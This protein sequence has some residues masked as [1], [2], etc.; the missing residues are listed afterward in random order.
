[1][2]KIYKVSGYWL[3]S[4]DT[5]S[6]CLITDSDESIDDDYENL[7][8]DDIFYYGMDVPKEMGNHEFKITEWEVLV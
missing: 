7:C 2:I 6:D 5:I 8:D 3:D 1:M 4:K